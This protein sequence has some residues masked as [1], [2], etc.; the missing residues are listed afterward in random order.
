MAND[1]AASGWKITSLEHRRQQLDTERCVR[2][3]HVDDKKTR[4]DHKTHCVINRSK[5]GYAAC[6]PGF[7]RCMVMMMMM[8]TMVTTS[9]LQGLNQ[10]LFFLRLRPPLAP[11][12]PS[13][14]LIFGIFV[15]DT[16]DPGPFIEHSNWENLTF[17]VCNFRHYLVVVQQIPRLV[18]EMGLI[19]HWVACV[20]RFELLDLQWHGW[21][22]DFPCN[23]S[24]WCLRCSHVNID[25]QEQN[26]VVVSNIFYVHPYLGRIPILTSTFQGVETTN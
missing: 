11:L 10:L 12:A 18:T 7:V 21:R 25:L 15:G 6:W 17:L 2:S 24:C 26:W 4:R 3:V 23:P 16:S 14:T 1:S 9:N 8:T 22:R 5:H 19:C 20:E 13:G